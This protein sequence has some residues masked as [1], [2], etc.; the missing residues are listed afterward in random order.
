MEEGVWFDRE[1]KKAV[2]RE[3]RRNGDEGGRMGSA[4]REEET[5][6]KC[7]KRVAYPFTFLSLGLFST[8][9]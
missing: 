2:V 5:R 4:G 3:E 9:E 7:D 8:L 1:S 6:A